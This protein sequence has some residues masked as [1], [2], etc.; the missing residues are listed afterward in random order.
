MARIRRL[1]LKDSNT[2]TFKSFRK[3]VLPGFADLTS[4]EDPGETA[5]SFPSFF[6][7]GETNLC[8]KTSGE[9]VRRDLEY[10]L[11]FTFI[12]RSGLTPSSRAL[13]QLERAVE[14]TKM[15]GERGR[16]SLWHRL[17]AMARQ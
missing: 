8:V 1:E 16:L 6:H 11:S 14:L 13:I 9:S 3:R 5:A 17:G 2:S 7:W 4:F 12:V 15:K 10:I